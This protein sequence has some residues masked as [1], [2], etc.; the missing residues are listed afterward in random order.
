[1]TLSSSPFNP[2]LV[3]IFTRYPEVGKT[4]TRMIPVLGAQ[5]AAN[6]QRQMTEYT[7]TTVKQL[8]GQFPVSIAIFYTGGNLQLVKTWLKNG[9]DY[10]NQGEGDL[11]VRLSSAFQR[12]FEQG[13][14]KVIIIG[15]DCPDITASI[16]RHGFE[17]LNHHDLVLGPAL[18][19]GYYLIGT[20]RPIPELFKDIFWGTGEVLQQTKAIAAKLDLK[21]A[22]LPPL[23][24][25]DRPEDLSI[26]QRV[27]D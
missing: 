1:M 3:I 21:M 26:W 6:L 9:Y 13:M 23:A 25:I 5:G 14:T 19:G 20:K 10:V 2:H 4:K 12:A 16:L 18:D 11:G 27:K 8:Q 22:F 15:I 7:L 17:M 24:D